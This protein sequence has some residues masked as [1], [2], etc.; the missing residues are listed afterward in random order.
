MFILHD[1]Q[2]KGI[3]AFIDANR[4]V[5]RNALFADYFPVPDTPETQELLRLALDTES[6]PLFY[7]MACP[8]TFKN[9]EASG[10]HHDA[11]GH[12]LTWLPSQAFRARSAP[13]RPTI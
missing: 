8:M 11:T 4:N 1:N 5:R 9:A 12:D 7:C 13:E 2:K 6:V 3:Q 10:A